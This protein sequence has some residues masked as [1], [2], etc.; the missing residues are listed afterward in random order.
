VCGNTTSTDF[1][2]TAG[3][4]NRSFHP[5]SDSTQAQDVFVAKLDPGGTKLLFSTFLGGGKSDSCYGIQVDQTGSVYVAGRTQSVDFP[6]TSGAYKT[7]RPTPETNPNGSTNVDGFVTKLSSS[8]SSLTY[9]TYMPTSADAIAIDSSG[10]AYVLVDG[11]G[12]RVPFNLP[13]TSGA[14]R[15][16]SS[17]SANLVKLN[18]AGSAVVYSTGVGPGAFFLGIVQVGGGSAIAVDSGGNAY[19]TGITADS[20]FPTTSGAYDTSYN[21]AVDSWLV[22][23]NPLGTQIVFATFLG[24]TSA[25]P[26]SLAID[27]DG[28]PIVGGGGSNTAFP[29]ATSYG[30]TQDSRNVLLLRFNSTGSQLVSSSLIGGSGNDGLNSIAIGSDGSVVVGGS[31]FSSDFP[32]TAD[33]ISSAPPTSTAAVGFIARLSPSF[34]KLVYATF[35]SGSNS[36][37][38]ISLDGTDAYAVGNTRGNLTTAGAL[39]SAATGGLDGFVAKISGLIGPSGP[40]APAITSVVSG[41]TFQPGIVAGSWV[42]II[43]R[44]LSDVTRT[45]QDSDFSGNT[46]PTSLSGVQVYFNGQP[47]AVYYISPTQL[48]V[49]APAPLIGNVAVQVIR[50]GISG[51]TVTANAV[52]SAPGLFTYSAGSKTYP[53]AVYPDGVLVGDPA[54]TPGARKAKAGDR[55]LLY[56]TGLGSSPAG[57]I[58]Q[59]ATPLGSPVSVSFGS[60]AGTVEFTGLVA[61]GEFQI[62]IV[63]PSL[64]D[65]DS[66][67]VLQ[68]GGLSSQTGVVIPVTH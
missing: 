30:Q 28:N 17:G 54:V 57:T 18:A 12:S 11:N 25:A 46:L 63:V 23:I 35:L 29:S 68:V 31:T 24:N 56:A 13:G 38:D 55:I 27:V 48:N 41:A 43:G 66:Q 37:F 16:V 51:N 62:N 40:V 22:K 65:G 39:Q 60:V 21:G 20:T 10:N 5:N 64:P 36:V 4:L 42:S 6:T 3:A 67:V 59:G 52:A 45:W 61:V 2:T 1:P 32:V 47:A 9:S 7:T 58:I 14:A 44:S 15:P 8:G 49:Q 34:D 53:A 19:V 26:V 33:A 50:N